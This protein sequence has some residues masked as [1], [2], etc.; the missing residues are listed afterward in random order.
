MQLKIVYPIRMEIK[1]SNT[2]GTPA[3]ALKV[4]AMH[5]LNRNDDLDRYGSA[6][7]LVAI[8]MDPSGSLTSPEYNHILIQ[9][10][11]KYGI[12]LPDWMRQDG[13]GAITTM[14]IAHPLGQL[15][16]RVGRASE[17]IWNLSAEMMFRKSDLLKQVPM[18]KT[19]NSRKDC[20]QRADD[21]EKNATALGAIYYQIEPASWDPE[22]NSGL[23][24]LAQK[25]NIIL[26]EWMRPEEL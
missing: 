22:L 11:N 1:E 17:V 9:R 6:I 2:E 24:D 25:Y 19:E 23:L 7:Y 16:G 3:S 5:M 13:T 4:V 26:P 12:A 10:A 21:L 18:T 8:Q 20:L 14:G 15:A